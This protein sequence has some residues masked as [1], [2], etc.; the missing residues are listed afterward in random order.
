MRYYNV[1]GIVH[2][3][4]SKQFSGVHDV[5][6]TPALIHYYRLPAAKAT[7]RGLDRV[8]VKVTPSARGILWRGVIIEITQHYLA[9]CNN[10]TP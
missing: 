2:G 7:G 8:V 9:W 1:T 10:M 3:A 5:N 6:Q 4:K